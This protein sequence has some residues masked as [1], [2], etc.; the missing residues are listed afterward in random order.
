MKS[1]LPFI[2]D[3][4]FPKFCINCGKD[5]SFLCEDCKAL[6]DISE[7]EYCLCDRPKRIP[8][9]KCG[10]CSSKSLDGLYFSAPY[11]DKIVQK[12]IHQFKDE[13]FIKDLSKP[14]TN[15]I[16]SHFL[17]LNNPVEKILRN[18]SLMAVPC[19]RE[20]K[21]KKGF[22]PS[23]EIARTLSQKTKL[24]LI[25]NCLKKNKKFRVLNKKAIQ[26][27]ELLLVDIIYDNNSHLEEIAKTL[28]EKGAKEVKGVV[29]ARRD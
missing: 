25:E 4:L 27:K 21:K 1:I 20:E 22:N 18:K 12:L 9:G 2:K 11:S 19:S 7:Y 13:P 10:K 24:P 6:V 28:K 8:S 16:I 17:L 15:L 3:I 26:G 23:F 14:L 29:V 5:G